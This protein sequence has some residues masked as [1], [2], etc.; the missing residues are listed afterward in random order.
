MARNLTTNATVV[1]TMNG[2]QA[3]ETMKKLEAESERLNKRLQQAKDSGDKISVA[4]LEKELAKVTSQLNMLR[5]STVQVEE[6]LRNLDKAKPAELQRALR[7][8]KDQLKGLERGSDLWNQHVANI[9]RVEQELSRVNAELRTQ[10]TIIDR[11]NG[12]WNKFQTVIMGVIAAMTGVI[13][14]GRG[15]VSEYAEIDE[16][17]ADTRKFT[18]MSKD[19]VDELNNS[20][21]AMSTRTARKELNSLA[22]EAGRL[23][24]NTQEAVMGYVRA[25]DVINVALSD[26]GSGATQD[27]A[28]LSNI[29]KIEDQYGTY[30]AML[31]I[32]SVVNVL[33]QNCTA[34][35][36][37]L[38]EFANRL[39]G[40]GNQA[41][42]SLQDIIGFGAVLDSN[43]QKVEASATAVSQV[44]T[45]MYIDPAKY[46]KVVKLNVQDFTKL[47]K[48]DANEALLQFLEALGKAGNMD[49]IAPMF[50]DMGENGARVITALSTLSKH[51]DEVRAQQIEANKAFEQ[52]TSVLNEYNIFNN[53]AQAGLDKAKKAAQEIAVELGE[54]LYPVMK[55]ILTTSGL[56]LR[57]LSTFVTFLL[58]HKK[59]II[60]VASAYAVYTVAVNYALLKTKAFHAIQVASAAVSKT[61][62][63]TLLSLSVMVNSFSGNTAR[64]A[65]A[66]RALNA[67]QAANPAGILIAAF[68]ALIALMVQ[69]RTKADDFKKTMDEAAKSATSFAD[70]V[71]KEKKNIDSLFGALDAC[72]KGTEEYDKAKNAIISKY[73]VYLKG[74]IDEKGEIINL[75][76]AYDRLTWA[77]EQSARARGI[78]KARESVDQSYLEDIG[79]L[80]EELRSELVKLKMP[81]RQLSSIM[82]QVSSFFGSGADFNSS[83]WKSIWSQIA[84]FT[85][86]NT[87]AFS[88]TFSDRRS[89]LAILGSMREHTRQRNSRMESFD[90]MENRKFKYL[91]SQS[92]SSLIDS[93]SEQIKSTPKERIELSLPVGSEEK[94]VEIL[95]MI[96]EGIGEKKAASLLKERKKTGS[97]SEIMSEAKAAAIGG[98]EFKF[99]GI[100]PM[101]NAMTMD[102][103]ISR[104]QAEMLLRYLLF[105]KNQRPE[106]NTTDNTADPDLFSTYTPVNGKN[107][108]DAA[109]R[110]EELKRKK[111]FKDALEA[112]KAQQIKAD[113]ELTAS[114]ANG[115]IE[116][117]EYLT[118]KHDNEKKFFDGSIKV[119]K[120]FFAASKDLY[121][122]DDKDYQALLSRKQEAELKFA[123]TI[124]QEKRKKLEK[125]SAMKQ[126]ELRLEFSKKPDTSLKDQLDLETDINEVK[127]D[128]LRR[129][130]D[131]YT[132][133][134]KE[135]LELNDKIFEVAQNLLDSSTEKLYSKV[136]EF[137][138]EYDKV[139]PAKKFRQE[140]EVLE[141]L[142]KKAYITAQEYEKLK[143]AISIKYES[144][145][146]GADRPLSA[147]E[148]Q[149]KRSREKKE[150]EQKIDSAILE[151]LISKEEGD[152]RKNWLDSQDLDSIL[153]SM[154][155]VAG[156]WADL[157]IDMGKAWKDLFIGIANDADGGLGKVANAAQATF[158]LLNAG[159]QMAAEFAE[160]ESKIAQAEITKRY[161]HEI[162][163]AQGN[164]YLVKKL[165]KEKEEKIAEEKNKASQKEY[166]MKIFS[167]VA[168][169]ASNAIAGYGAGLQAGFPMALWLAPMLAGL[170]VAQGAV[171]VALLTKQQQAAAA[172]G[173]SE[174]GFTKPGEKEEVAGV[175]HAGEWV[176]S[177]RLLKSPVTRPVI[178]WLER[179]QRTNTIGSLTPVDASRIVTSAS[180]MRTNGEQPGQPQVIVRE[181]PSDS[182]SDRLGDVVSRLAQ[183]LD[184]PFVTVNTMTGDAG[185]LRAQDEYRK[186]IANK[187]RLLRR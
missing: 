136:A 167:A 126:R 44:L 121:L 146:P 76:A 170:A 88:Y 161:D 53:T 110:R 179:A 187:N 39:A 153:S 173:Y 130:R 57:F 171:Q 96:S 163:L 70:E 68:T 151:G 145:I 128:Y 73:G 13:A 186:Y 8:L 111:E 64:A 26:L 164:S 95:T 61:W 176:A 143:K 23:G 60:S 160:E 131:L 37:Y 148:I 113:A 14:A 43:A 122:E 69:F 149:D 4:K 11:L 17:L 34:S 117:I 84:G 16:S 134:S 75:A 157:C 51:I 97:L 184:E 65:A 30:D 82:S 85:K 124:I 50:K 42:L 177:Q 147:G 48:E 162:K 181:I 116:Y 35:K 3:N 114:Y 98:A 104:G 137:H 15:A 91:P 40:V 92:I 105:E 19:S 66:Q 29:F 80:T 108:T 45:R 94:A 47:L 54:K 18:S 32:G 150:R 172:S 33:S 112:V 81:Q 106:A 135:W 100:S 123:A 152:R 1:I 63:N 86:D 89:P 159:F 118:R 67:A 31:K 83:Q 180:G 101:K 79:N 144:Q 21:K 109:A 28:K 102:A 46:A 27:I 93:L 72:K 10:Q 5:T 22:Q 77:A 174:G 103:T 185:I 132:R 55:H 41:H 20:F 127:I 182:S 25:A 166:R 74:L 78:A 58:S 133:A 107:N 115:E 36:P 99:N 158:A 175:V 12:W 154:K 2:K 138:R 9:R 169:T 168:Q 141:I 178:D 155:G 156:E 139:S 62:R 56:M 59:A 129:Q 119:Y 6:V 52:G 142:A 49:I 24:K 71:A 120:K 38:V 7:T 165:E 183:R 125:E 90:E 87:S 140:I